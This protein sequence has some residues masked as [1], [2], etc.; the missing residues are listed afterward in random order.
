M[1]ILKKGI[2]FQT[3]PLKTLLEMK[4]GYSNH[5]LSH[6][7]YFFL[8][9]ISTEILSDRIAILKEGRL[10]CCGS[11]LFLQQRY[12]LGYNLTVVVKQKSEN[13]LISGSMIDEEVTDERSIITNP[14]DD[15]DDRL[16]ELVKRLVPG[17][18]QM[19]ETSGERMYRLKQGSEEKVCPY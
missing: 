4:I 5:S 15:N 1:S 7:L 19:R 14:L 16:D 2:A 17:S 13:A 6:F 9:H 11:L 3:M 10:Q 8:F 18:W 12:G